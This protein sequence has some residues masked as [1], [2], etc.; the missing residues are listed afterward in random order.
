[1]DSPALVQ[2]PIVGSCVD[3]N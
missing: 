2:G 3:S 1:L